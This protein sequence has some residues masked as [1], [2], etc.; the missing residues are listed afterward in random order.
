[1]TNLKNCG[2]LFLFHFQKISW[3]LT[4]KVVK[5]GVVHTL[6]SCR[7]C[8]LQKSDFWGPELDRLNEKGVKSS[9][10]WERAMVLCLMSVPE[11]LGSLTQSAFWKIE[12]VCQNMHRCLLLDHGIR[13]TAGEAAGS[14]PDL[15]SIPNRGWRS[16]AHRWPFIR[17]T[18]CG[19]C[20]DQTDTEG[21]RGEK[22]FLFLHE[23][24]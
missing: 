5:K 16:A 7:E 12:I 15:R 20:A 3:E 24:Y 4:E 1:M 17:Q 6:Y 13:G 10:I 22:I 2:V 23:K 11:R 18:A 14:L 19:L 8:D 21:W 9:G